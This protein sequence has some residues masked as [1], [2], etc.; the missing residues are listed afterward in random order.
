M[1]CY[2]F[3]GYC[4]FFDGFEVEVVEIV[5]GVGVYGCVC[6]DC[7][8]GCLLFFFCGVRVGRSGDYF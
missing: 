6:C 8:F 2:D 1:V 3:V 7:I 4:W 5:V